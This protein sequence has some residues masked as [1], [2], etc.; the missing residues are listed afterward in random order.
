MILENLKNS[1]MGVSKNTKRKGLQ[2]FSDSEEETS[3]Q[4][5][6]SAKQSLFG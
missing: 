2:I 6:L 1:S 4:P 5:R 3:H